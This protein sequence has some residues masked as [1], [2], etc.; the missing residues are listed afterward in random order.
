[1]RLIDGDFSDSN[2]RS[3]SDSSLLYSA[4]LAD[5]G[6][7]DLRSISG[8]REDLNNIISQYRP[9]T[10]D[11]IRLTYVTDGPRLNQVRKM[12]VQDLTEADRLKARNL[13]TARSKKRCIESITRYHDE[14]D[15]LCSGRIWLP[16]G[17]N[18]DTISYDA[19]LN[20]RKIVKRCRDNKRDPADLW[21]PGGDLHDVPYTKKPLDAV[22]KRL[23]KNSDE[24][25]SDSGPKEDECPDLSEETLNADPPQNKD[26]LI[27]D[28]L[29][30]HVESE[31]NSVSECTGFGGLGDYNDEEVC[32]HTAHPLGALTDIY[33][34]QSDNHDIEDPEHGRRSSPDK[35]QSNFPSGLSED[36]PPDIF[37]DLEDPS[38]SSPLFRRLSTN[39]QIRPNHRVITST[40]VAPQKPATPEPPLIQELP[41]TPERPTPTLQLATTPQQATTLDAVS[42][43]RAEPQSPVSASSP[44]RQ[45]L[46]APAQFALKSAHGFNI[47]CLRDGKLVEGTVIAEVLRAANDIF[48]F[49]TVVLDPLL[50]KDNPLPNSVRKRLAAEPTAI[51]LAPINLLS[52]AR[53]WVLVVITRPKG[54]IN[55][56]DS[57]PEATCEEELRTKLES[58]L[59]L[60]EN[61]DD[62]DQSHPHFGYSACPRQINGVDCRIATIVNAL[63]L[64][65][66]FPIPQTTD[67]AIWRRILT[68]FCAGNRM[69]SSLSEQ[70][71]KPPSISNNINSQPPEAPALGTK[72]DFAAWAK[73][74]DTYKQDIMNSVQKQQDAWVVARERVVAVLEDAL[75]LCNGFDGIDG[76]DAFDGKISGYLSAIQG[77]KMV[78]P[79]EEATIS[80]LKA[81]HLQLL[82]M[83]QRQMEVRMAFIRVREDLYHEYGRIVETT[84]EL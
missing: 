53:H 1:M 59:A 45:R 57:L 9:E 18:V 60:M 62:R 73:D 27:D 56:L 31:T 22:W 76:A 43:K 49:S 12:M 15:N 23:V 19:I 7:Q 26:P 51:V 17:I 54:S 33:F 4:F 8:L 46:A 34:S 68:A 78:G 79:T 28:G 75:G 21:G 66:G 67:Y 20:I 29:G 58:L 72:A 71:A 16:K 14:L 40:L 5:L 35:D 10:A 6:Q 74:L 24:V 3:D 83:R 32:Y 2:A 39:V 69:D 65:A 84:V 52:K 37:D 63:H 38:G 11:H 36:N 61:Q 47:D 25:P 30:R 55:V 48:P 44:K 42:P 77:L 13:T 41:V 82:A 70:F 80:R 64:M 81:K 50:F